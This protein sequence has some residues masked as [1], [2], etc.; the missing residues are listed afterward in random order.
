MPII[1]F[2]VH[3]RKNSNQPELQQS[4][5]ADMWDLGSGLDLVCYVRERI[6]LHLIRSW[7][8]HTSE[9]ERVKYGILWKAI[10]YTHLHKYERVMHG[11]LWKAIDL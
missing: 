9:Y 6:L 8:T 1:I 11:I 4:A 10:G 5:A 3:R 2:F 7:D